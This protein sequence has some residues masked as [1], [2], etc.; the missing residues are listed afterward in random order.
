MEQITLSDIEAVLD[1]IGS[2]DAAVRQQSTDFVAHLVSERPTEYTKL[3]LGV[4]HHTQKL[5]VFI[6]LIAQHSVTI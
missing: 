4:P 2:P 3:F 5:N 6:V 1:A